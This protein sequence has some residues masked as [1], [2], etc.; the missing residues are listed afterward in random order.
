MECTKIVHFLERENVKT[1]TSAEIT[2]EIISAA[3]PDD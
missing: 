2:S 1:E 3:D